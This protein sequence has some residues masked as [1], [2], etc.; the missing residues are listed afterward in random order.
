MHGLETKLFDVLPDETWIY[1]GHGAD[2]N[3]GNERP[4]LGEWRERGW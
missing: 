4:H 1:P 3:I 2:S